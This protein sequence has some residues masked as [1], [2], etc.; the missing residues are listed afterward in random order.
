MSYT[1]RDYEGIRRS[2][3]RSQSRCHF[4]SVIVF[5][6]KPDEFPDCE[7]V[8]IPRITPAAALNIVNL[9]IIPAHTDRYGSHILTNHWDSWVQNPGA[10]RDDWLEFDYIGA[11]WPDG[12]VGNDGFALISSRFL[13]AVADLHIPATV[14]HCRPADVVVCRDRHRGTAKCYRTELEAAG[15]SYAHTDTAS[16]FSTEGDYSGQ[17][18]FHGKTAVLSLVRQGLL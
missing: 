3:A 5:T 1:T 13:R 11:P 10:W 8:Q 9:T 4:H 17:F 18:G 15:M 12:V 2:L 16:Q 6:D 14:R 7:T